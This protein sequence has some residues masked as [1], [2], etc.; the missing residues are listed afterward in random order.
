M[1]LPSAASLYVIALGSNRS[2]R[3]GRPAQEVTAALLLLGD[4][5]AVSPVMMTPPLGPASRRYANAA[6][7]ITTPETPP[8][9]LARL[10]A[11][12][13][14]FGRRRGQRWG[15]RVLDL[16]IILWSQGAWSDRQVTVPHPAFRQRHFVL[17]P[18]MRVAPDWRDSV[19]GLTVRQL[20]H[21][22]RG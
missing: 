6:A 18:L 11:V 8:V 3:H 7:V 22:L 1:R 14:A 13:R 5:I 16:D 19:T 2:G 4:V 15:S 17:E 12:E 21:R 9:L 10:K 20:H